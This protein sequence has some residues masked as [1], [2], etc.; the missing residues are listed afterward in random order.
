MPSDADKKRGIEALRAK[1]VTLDRKTKLR[2]AIG[3][4]VVVAGLATFAACG[5]CGRRS[6]GGA[7]TTAALSTS[8]GTD[9]GR[10]VLDVD[11]AALRDPLL[12]SNAKDGDVE[13][14]ATLAA[15]EGAA[16]LAEAMSEPELRK[17]ALR[18]MGYARGWSQLPV[19]AKAA[20]GKDDE[21]ARLALDSTVELAT[22]PRRSED[23]EDAGELREGCEALGVLARDT[24]RPRGRRV[25]ALRS[26]RMMPC[27]KL[28][29]PDDLDAK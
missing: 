6:P 19:L 20:S 11:A 1:L 26:L 9:A 16:G 24:A 14:L 13:D 22:R 28:E 7:G 4:G 2:V 15:H 8:N 12:W 25:A 5:G 21:E 10:S 18:A 17:V 29:L 27:P 3:G 23:P